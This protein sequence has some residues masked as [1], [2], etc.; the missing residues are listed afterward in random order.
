MLAL[1]DSRWS[2]LSGEYRVPYDPRPS[3]QRLADDFLDRGTWEELW[4]ELHH[5]GDLGEASYAAVPHLI[6]L[7]AAAPKRDW[8]VYALVATIET[9]R[10]RHNNPPLP[11]YLS[12]SFTAGLQQLAEL[13]LSDLQTATDRYV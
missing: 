8:N 4:G 2:T 3:L 1:T 11:E 12:A 6:R 13:A 10:H 9:E 5:Q 7:A